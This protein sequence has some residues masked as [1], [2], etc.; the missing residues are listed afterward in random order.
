MV[1]KGGNFTITNNTASSY[2]IFL[3]NKGN[4]S[5]TDANNNVGAM[6]YTVTA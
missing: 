1:L 6:R 5:I 3:V 2:N 4:N